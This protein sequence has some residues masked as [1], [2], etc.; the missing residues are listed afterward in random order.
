MTLTIKNSV[1]GTIETY[2]CYDMTVVPTAHFDMHYYTTFEG[3]VF[4][5][6]SYFGAVY[7]TRENYI[8][9]IVK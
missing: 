1:R 3:L 7:D 6:H 5:V 4:V 9:G 8:G 2:E